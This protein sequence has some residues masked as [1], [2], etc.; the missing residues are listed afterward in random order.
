MNVQTSPSFKKEA[1]KTVFSILVFAFTY[2][3]L[4]ILSIGLT[5]ACVYAGIA[6]IAF[7]PSIPTLGLGLA[8]IASAFTILI[9]L[10]KFIFASSKTDLSHLTEISASDEPRLFTLITEIV[11]EV[12]TKFP[13]KVY[14][15]HDVN[16]SVFY[17]SNFWS[18][19]LPI[20][21][22][23]QIG[24][25]LVNSVTQQELK[26][27]LAHEF[28][29]FSQKSMK[30]GSY[31]Y[32]VNQIIYN[33]LYK[34][35][36]LNKMNEKWASI[37]GYAVIFI[38][39]SAF[40][41]KGIQKILQQL[42]AYIN[43]NYMALSR[44]MEFHADE[45]AANV[46]GSKALSESLLRLSFSNFALENVLS[47]Y[48]ERVK[49]NVKSQNLYTE[50]QFVMQFLATKN[51]YPFRGAFP[52]IELEQIKKYNKSK[53]NIENQWASHPSDEDR[54][55]ALNR[56]NII[57]TNT[58]DSPA[59]TLFE[60]NGAIAKQISNAL[61]AHIQYA[62]TPNELNPEKFT[63]EFIADF[64]KNAF[65]ELY[66]GFYDNNNPVIEGLPMID[67]SIFEIEVQELFNDEKVEAIYELVALKN[68]KEILLAIQ[69]DEIKIKTFDYNGIKHR[70]DEAYLVLQKVEEEIAEKETEI[71]NNNIAVFRF[72]YTLARLQNREGELYTLYSE[73]VKIDKQYDEKINFYNS[74]IET[75]NFIFQTTP[76][77][78]ITAHLEDLK[79]L[80]PKLKNELTALLKAPLI[81]EK[82]DE[83]AKISLQ[84][85]TQNT[86][87][88]FNV[89][90]YHDDNLAHLFSAINY[91]HQLMAR[92][93]FLKK[94]TILR[95]QKELL[96]S[97]GLT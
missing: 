90:A 74:L 61:F 37:N 63:E 32:N 56:L 42:Y 49:L 30:L 95:F 15:S 38:G 50:Q 34:N 45:I 21:K 8:L 3:L 73:F 19:F 22:N 7:T 77:D 10:I 85:Y 36:S 60:N 89:D 13:K 29:H 83:S 70:K 64:E 25:G 62:E 1:K 86:L 87:H 39:A 93:Y 44:E 65:D 88:Y 17:D 14:L 68:D 76:F 12:D 53:L 82:L 2:L 91:Y 79:K 80:E 67:K 20:Q 59:I 9:Y 6:L 35:E 26:A 11:Q 81:A 5:A 51:K 16:A 48:D 43:I 84:T 97:G 92:Q 47:F 24:M 40:V 75:T 52:V 46:A 57:K 94:Q 54:I 55:N 96:S 58:D 31:V 4:F 72:F 18:M 78:E 33:M 41:I 66:N 23:L 28:G 69:K 27:I 71:R